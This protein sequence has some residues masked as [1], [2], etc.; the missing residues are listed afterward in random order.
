MKNAKI[1]FILFVS[2]SFCS[3][4]GKKI[5]DPLPSWNDGSTKK[6]I[7]EFVENATTEGHKNFIQQEDRIATFD[8]DGTL[9]SEVPI[10]E[11]SFINN[12]L[13]Q[14]LARNPALMRKEPFRT[15]TRDGE[16]ALA[17]LK[18]KD[19][20]TIM[21]TALSGTT[22][23]EF[24]SQARTFLQTAQH[25]KYR[26][27][28]Q[29]LTYKPMMELVS[30]LQHEGFKVY[31]CSGG[32]V[33]FMRVIAPEIYNIPVE[34][35]IGSYFVDKTVERAGKL[36]IMRTAKLITTNDQAEKPVNILQ[37]IGRRPVFAAGNVRNG[38]DI[39]HLRYSSEGTLPS[40]QLMINHDDADREAA[41]AEPN[42][43]SLIAAKKFNWHVV[44]IKS[45]WKQIFNNLDTTGLTKLSKK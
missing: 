5:T 36:V 29:N 2:I 33:A 12:Q 13:K 25:P 23:E 31:I 40:L 3:C 35:V 39:E 15:I 11:V 37:R 16:K 7:I 30:Y 9:W 44:S 22:E 28:Y 18:M 14:A 8:N 27:P 20:I 6:A 1:I 24:A 42:N 19:I 10:A 17:K 26:V 34:N 21:T 41:Y 38:G 43:A 32:D 4:T 45:D